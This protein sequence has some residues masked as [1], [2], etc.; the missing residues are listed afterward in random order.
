MDQQVQLYMQVE[1]VHRDLHWVAKQTLKF[2]HKYCTCKLK[3]KTF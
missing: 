1:L 3:K 2:P